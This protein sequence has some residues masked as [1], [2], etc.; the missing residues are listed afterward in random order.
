M[1]LDASVMTLRAEVRWREEAEGALRRA[2]AT[3]EDKV[4][5]R[6]ADLARLNATLRE[7][8]ERLRAV[9]ET[10]VE[11]IITIDEGGLVQSINPAALAMFGYAPEELIGQNVNLLMDSPERERHDGYIANYLRTGKAKIIGIGREVGARR[12]NGES[13]PIEL[14]VTQVIVRGQRQFAGFVRDI[15]ARKN[16]ADAL[17]AS[18]ARL[19]ELYGHLQSV[20]DDE[21][22]RIARELHDE[23]G[24]ALTAV[25]VN[26]DALLNHPA[27]ATQAFPR[28]LI[29]QV[30]TLLD[31]VIGSMHRIVSELRP[32]VIDE[33][34][35]WSALETLAREAE[36][37]FRLHC[38][39]DLP[40]AEAKLP[41]ALSMGLYR[42]AQEALNNAAKH[43]EA[44]SVHIRAALHRDVVLLEIVDDGKGMPGGAHTN[45]AW[46]LLGMQERAA[47]LGGEV[48]I[49]SA[50]QRGTRVHVRL[51]LEREPAAHAVLDASR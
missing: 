45:K 20:R 32:G 43:A 25:Q 14:S 2:H 34:G 35:V 15:S 8:E 47:S 33:L 17:R 9:V 31:R 29:V 18:H 10:A 36:R 23:L 7:S 24:S 42:I 48:R 16:A 37:D 3:L 5:E 40:P 19:R 1:Q 4:R 22:K 49:E 46:G 6:T 28:E 27:A 13:F 26:L 50:P 39:I 44:S 12:K 51:P 11:G 30:Q 41:P 38:T 21:Q